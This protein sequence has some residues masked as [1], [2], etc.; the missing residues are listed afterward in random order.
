MGSFFNSFATIGVQHCILAVFSITLCT[1][2][3]N[4]VLSND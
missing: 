3:E 2:S 4:T 1:F